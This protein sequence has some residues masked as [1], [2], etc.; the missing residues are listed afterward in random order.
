MRHVLPGTRP[1]IVHGAF[2][3]DTLVHVSAK[4]E[5]LLQVNTQMPRVFGDGVIHI[6]HFDTM[7]EGVL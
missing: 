1:N 2:H 6:S 5:L 7:I 4:R 3:F